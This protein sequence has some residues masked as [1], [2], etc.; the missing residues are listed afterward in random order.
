MNP[1]FFKGTVVERQADAWLRTNAAS[2]GG[3]A[4]H[5]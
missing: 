3:A 4:A 2:N 5:A 1:D